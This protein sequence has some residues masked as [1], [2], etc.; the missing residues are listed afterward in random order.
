[1]GAAGGVVADLSERGDVE[2]VVE[3]TVAVRVEAMTNARP[4]DASMGAVA[5]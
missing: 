2:C 5:L 3:V 1:M 4:D